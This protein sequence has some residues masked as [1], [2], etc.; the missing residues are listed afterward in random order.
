M[1]ETGDG[2]STW[3]LPPLLMPFA[4]SAALLLALASIAAAE[5]YPTRPV[6][7]I[8]PFPPG[9]SNDVVGCLVASQLSERLGSRSLSITVGE[10]EA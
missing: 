3:E 5:D 6:R 7:L 10:P 2:S 4:C 9:G 1:Q 8:V